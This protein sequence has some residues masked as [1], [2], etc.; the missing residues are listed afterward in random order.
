[1][2]F[3][4]NICVVLF[5]FKYIFSFNELVGGI[6]ALWVFHHFLLRDVDTMRRKY[7]TGSFAQAVDRKKF[8]KKKTGTR[9]D[10]NKRYVLI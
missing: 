9:R 1:M 7:V 2:A 10:I 4:T 3:I 5:F 8:E 6:E